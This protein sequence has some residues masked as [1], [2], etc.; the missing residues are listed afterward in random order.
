MAV[1]VVVGDLLIN[2]TYS[3]NLVYMST[4]IFKILKNLNCYLVSQCQ[5][6][7]CS[8]S[9]GRTSCLEFCGCRNEGCRNKCNMM[10]D[11]VGN[12]DSNNCDSDD[13]NDG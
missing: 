1:V 8:C 13:E 4:F 5:T 3:L 7:S 10:P 12:N 2:A 9:M 11:D 6:S